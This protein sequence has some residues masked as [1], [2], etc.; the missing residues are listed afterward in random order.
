MGLGS[1]GNCN[2]RFHVM[3]VKYRQYAQ[4]V[5]KISF[6]NGVYF[7]AVS[8]CDASLIQAI[9]CT[10]M[11]CLPYMHIL[12]VCRLHFV[13]LCIQTVRTVL[14]HH[15]YII[16]KVLKAILS[17]YNYCKHKILRTRHLHNLILVYRNNFQQIM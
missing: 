11:I 9:A 14:W 15:S 10:Y 3:K 6:L 12:A 17:D 16:L 7:F 1:V 13:Q 2:T 4:L 5:S 8:T